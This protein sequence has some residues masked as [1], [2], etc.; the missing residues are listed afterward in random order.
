MDTNTKQGGIKG[1][2]LIYQKPLDKKTTAALHTLAGH[3]L[4]SINKH[5]ITLAIKLDTRKEKK[6]KHPHT[7]TDATLCCTERDLD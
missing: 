3:G 7:R 5:S 2:K 1:Y 4:G 6:K